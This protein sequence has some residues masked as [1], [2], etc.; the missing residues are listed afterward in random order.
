[1]NRKASLIF[2]CYTNEIGIDCEKSELENG[3]C[4][5]LRFGAVPFCS[6][7]EI[8]KDLIIKTGEQFT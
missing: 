7:S 1:M 5:Y 6:N 4:K 8:K 3:K 2:V